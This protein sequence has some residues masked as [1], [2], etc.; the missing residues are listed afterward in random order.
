MSVVNL[1]EWYIIMDFQNYLGKTIH[2]L[3]SC[4]SPLML[5]KL[6]FPPLPNRNL[7]GSSFFVD[8]RIWCIILCRALSEVMLSINGFV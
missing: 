3:L 1:I 8:N 4:L 6:I 2:L 5:K 7:S